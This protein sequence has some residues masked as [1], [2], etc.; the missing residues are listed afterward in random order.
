[1]AQFSHDFSD[2]ASRDNGTPC[3][4]TLRLNLCP[5]LPK[6]TFSTLASCRNAPAAVQKSEA[7]I[8][9]ALRLFSLFQITL[10]QSDISVLL[11][12]D[13]LNRATLPFL[14]TC[15]VVVVVVTTFQH[16]SR[17]T[18]ATYPKTGARALCTVVQSKVG[19]FSRILRGACRHLHTS[20]IYRPIT[21]SWLTGLRLQHRRSD[22]SQK[23]V[24]KR[25]NRGQPS[26]AALKHNFLLA[27]D[28]AHHQL[29]LTFP[30]QVNSH[31]LKQKLGKRGVAAIWV[32][33]LLGAGWWMQ[34]RVVDG[35]IMPGLILPNARP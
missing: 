15:L 30:E 12:R 25:K 5:T 1:M 14:S 32:V 3:D 11:T 18:H 26:F 2:E 7:N 17:S 19:V 24:F 4:T 8:S 13:Q 6:P 33:P 28:A 23:V 35:P 9:K 21:S 29:D 20:K 22:L 16:R 10:F 34:M 27:L 31:K